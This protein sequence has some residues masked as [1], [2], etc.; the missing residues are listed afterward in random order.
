MMLRYTFQYY[1]ARLAFNAKLPTKFRISKSGPNRL[2]D[3]GLYA[4]VKHMQ[5]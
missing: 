3:V 4:Y 1:E 5:H 2:I